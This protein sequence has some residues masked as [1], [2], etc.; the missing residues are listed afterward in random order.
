MEV[1][2]DLNFLKQFEF[3]TVKYNDIEYLKLGSYS[4][5]LLSLSQLHIND[6]EAIYAGE[7]L[8]LKSIFVQCFNSYTKCY[9]DIINEF[10]NC[11][12]SFEELKR[13]LFIEMTFLIDQNQLF[14]NFRTNNV[15]KL[16]FHFFNDF[17]DELY[18]RIE[19]IDDVF[20]IIK[21]YQQR[22]DIDL[23]DNDFSLEEIENLENLSWLEWNN[24]C[25]QAVNPNDLKDS[26]IIDLSP[27]ILSIS[28]NKLSIETKITF[29]EAIR[30]EAE[31]EFEKWYMRFCIDDPETDKLEAIL[32]FK[33]M[34]NR[35][36][37][38][39]EFSIEQL[40]QITID[41]TN[42]RISVNYFKNNGRKKFE[43]WLDGK[44]DVSR[45]RE[46]Y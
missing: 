10:N 19:E 27:P 12:V 8:H 39:K 18:K 41:R 7:L 46:N 26:N 32:F 43:N 15:G 34:N 16:T 9:N 28:R 23:F 44:P 33:L 6:F 38:I 24:I 14:Y 30:P 40:H 45:F 42:R 37:F 25:R 36:Y 17:L 35:G 13:K 20:S 5:D 1:N 29:N 31:E 3:A 22:N 2:M 4:E 21:P 11:S